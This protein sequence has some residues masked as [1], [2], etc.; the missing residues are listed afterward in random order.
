MIDIVDELRDLVTRFDERGVEYALCGGMAMG[1]HGFMRATMDIDFLIP[2]S[3]LDAVMTIAGELGYTIRGKDLSFKDGAVEIRRISKIDAEGE[4]LP[5][6]F[7][8][9][10]PT[11]ERVWDS[12]VNAEWKFGRLTIVTRD[13][14]IEMKRLRNSG[15]DIADIER[16]LSEDNN[17]PS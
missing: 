13:G 9:V 5:L 2:V 16:L 14:L 6:D 10:T 11:N 7:I 1:V 3:A 4:L 8:L 17:A 12:R 15:Q